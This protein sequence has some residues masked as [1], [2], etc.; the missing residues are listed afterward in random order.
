MTKKVSVQELVADLIAC[1]LIEGNSG[2]FPAEQQTKAA[3]QRLLD[4]ITQLRGNLSLAEEGL[5]KAAQELQR[6][7]GL[8]D[9]WFQVAGKKEAELA[10]LRASYQT[11]YNQLPVGG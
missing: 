1:A 9:H 8:V 10:E 6:V 4:E 2:R 7:Y 3:K 5:A 11:V